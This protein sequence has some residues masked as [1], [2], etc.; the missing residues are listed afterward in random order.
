MVL[1][2]ELNGKNK[3]TAIN[4]WAVAVFRDRGKEYYS[5]NRVNWKTWIGI[6]G[7]H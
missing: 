2:S 6:Q 1:K 7:K 4:T 3:I 5:G